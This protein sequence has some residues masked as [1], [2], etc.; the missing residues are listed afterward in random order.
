MLS[1]L[2]KRL[3]TIEYRE[4]VGKASVGPT[5]VSIKGV[6][7]PLTERFLERLATFQREL[8]E[9]DAEFDRTVRLAQETKQ[10]KRSKIQT[11]FEEALKNGDS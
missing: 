5:E 8:A 10:L 9:A 2:R 3:T 4:P 7:Y 6:V 11:A 1:W